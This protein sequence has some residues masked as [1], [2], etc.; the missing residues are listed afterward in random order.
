MY[1]AIIMIQFPLL[2][3]ERSSWTDG[4]QLYSGF[5][6]TSVLVTFMFCNKTLWQN[7]V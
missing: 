2:Q 6:Y 7:Q 1:L 5:F 3:N 4:L